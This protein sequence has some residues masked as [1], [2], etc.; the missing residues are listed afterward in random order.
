[1]K[2][3]D[4]TYT[5]EQL[6]R[7]VAPVA[8]DGRWLDDLS[9]GWTHRTLSKSL[10]TAEKARKYGFFDIRASPLRVR[11]P[12]SERYL[13]WMLNMYGEPFLETT[14]SLLVYDTVAANRGETS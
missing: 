7:V 11:D 14:V 10:R 13:K 4:R 8:P 3:E 6:A 12:E 9:S 1:M 2:P 5:E